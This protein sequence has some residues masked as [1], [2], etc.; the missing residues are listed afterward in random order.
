MKK[1]LFALALSAVLVFSLAAC[2]GQSSANNSTTTDAATSTTETS[3][4]ASTGEAPDYSDKACWYQLP[5]IKKDVDTFFVYP[6]EY[7]A[8]NEGD[9]DFAPLDNAEMLEGVKTNYPILASVYEDSTNVFMPYYR[10]AAM[11]CCC[12]TQSAS[13]R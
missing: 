6:T 10:Q 2:G 13:I 7:M 1:R 12:R 9:P 8:A 4:T 11:L 5:E 3:T